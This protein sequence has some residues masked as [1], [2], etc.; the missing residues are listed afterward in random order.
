M[1]DSKVAADER[2]DSILCTLAYDLDFF[3]ADERTRGEDCSLYGPER[4]VAEI[5]Q[6]LEQIREIGTEELGRG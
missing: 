5:F 1:W 4:L 3:E 2:A 6:A